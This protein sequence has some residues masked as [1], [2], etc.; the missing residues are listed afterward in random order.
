MFIMLATSSETIDPGK[1]KPVRKSFSTYLEGLATCSVDVASGTPFAAPGVVKVPVVVED[2]HSPLHE[3]ADIAVSSLR[4]R[5]R[6]PFL[7]ERRIER[8]VLV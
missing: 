7:K 8:A 3:R 2:S 6:E 4:S 1:P 5:T